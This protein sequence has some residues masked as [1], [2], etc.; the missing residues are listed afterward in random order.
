[1]N[2]SCDLGLYESSDETSRLEQIANVRRACREFGFFHLRNHDVPL[3][4]Q[5]A[6]LTMAKQL[7]NLPQQTKDDMS[8]ALSQKSRG[9]S[10]VGNQQ[11]DP[12]GLPDLKESYYITKDFPGSGNMYPPSEKIPAFR[13]TADNYYDTMIQLSQRLFR[14]LAA[15]LPVDPCYFDEYS[16]VNGSAASWTGSTLRLVHYPQRPQEVSERQMACGSHTDFGSITLLLQDEITGLEIKP[17]TLSDW[18][19]VPP[20]RDIYV[21]NIGDLMQKWTNG[22]YVSAVHRVSHDQTVDRYSVPFFFNGNWDYLIQPLDSGLEVG[23]MP[24]ANRESF[25]VGSHILSRLRQT[26]VEGLAAD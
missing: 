4:K 7:F 24:K 10:P 15:S 23:S 1:M 25:T 21:V 22:E 9:Y 12:E 14:L 19:A 3:E 11:L 20:I 26:H 6:I 2:R 16:G 17:P 18:I 8:L 5:D 13:R